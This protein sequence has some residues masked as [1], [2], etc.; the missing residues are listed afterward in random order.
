[1]ETQTR[2]FKAALVNGFWKAR[3]ERGAQCLHAHRS[4]R[5]ATNCA[6]QCNAP[7]RVEMHTPQAAY[8]RAAGVYN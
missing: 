6:A 4:E 3:D 2:L 8:D 7:T 5:A 1:M